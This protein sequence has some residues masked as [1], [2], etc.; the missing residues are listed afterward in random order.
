[1]DRLSCYFFFSIRTIGVSNFISFRDQAVRTFV[2]LSQFFSRH[3]MWDHH[4][5][6]VSLLWHIYFL[7]SI[8]LSGAAL[9]AA[10][11][12]DILNWTMST[13]R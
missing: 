1:M 7:L 10:V 11:V 5:H 2:S 8:V 9:R 13:I 6:C 4:T 12:Q 3:P